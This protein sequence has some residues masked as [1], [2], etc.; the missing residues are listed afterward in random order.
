MHFPPSCDGPALSVPLSSML[1]STSPNQDDGDGEDKG[2]SCG[3]TEHGQA[4][5]VFSWHFYHHTTH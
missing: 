2:A 3:G 1:T 5:H 4:F